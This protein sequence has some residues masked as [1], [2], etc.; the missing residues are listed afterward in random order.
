MHLDER[1]KWL[2]KVGSQVENLTHCSTQS[3]SGSIPLLQMYDFSCLLVPPGFLRRLA[4]GVAGPYGTEEQP[5]QCTEPVL[6]T[7]VP[8]A[9]ELVKME[10]EGRRHAIV[11]QACMGNRYHDTSSF[12]VLV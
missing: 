12:P 7:A 5:V 11:T 1:V 10:D 2:F 6:K 4:K 3:Q 9:P 8:S